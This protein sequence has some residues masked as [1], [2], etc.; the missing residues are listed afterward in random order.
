MITGPGLF[1]W[2]EF[3]TQFG[4][5]VLRKFTN[6]G[7]LDLAQL[8][9]RKSDG[10]HKSFQLHQSHICISKY[11]VNSFDDSDFK[12]AL[13]SLYKAALPPANKGKRPFAPIMLRRLEK[14]DITTNKIPDELTQEERAR[15]VRLDID[16]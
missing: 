14:L 7:D 6:P 5:L 10:V 8:M 4:E 1:A 12:L 9:V 11:H 2:Q 16:P 3:G 15:F 13:F